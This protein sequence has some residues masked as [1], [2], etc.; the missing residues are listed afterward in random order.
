VTQQ[1]T[2]TFVRFRISP[3]PPGRGKERWAWAPC[4]ED[5]PGAQPH[6]HWD[7]GQGRRVIAGWRRS[8]QVE[9]GFRSSEYANT[10]P[11]LGLAK[12]LEYINNLPWLEV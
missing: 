8:V 7:E 10:T 6:Y 12:L 5:T 4:H 2:R 11:R 9:R 1:R 3:A